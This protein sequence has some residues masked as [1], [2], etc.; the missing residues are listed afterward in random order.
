[1]S[2]DFPLL[3]AA[4]HETGGQPAMT[5][6]TASQSTVPEG[7]G[8]SDTSVI[9]D[10]EAYLRSY[11]SFPD[12]RYFLPLALFAALSTAGTSASTRSRTCRS[13]LQS[14]R[15]ARP[16]S[17]SCSASLPGRRGP[18]SSTAASPRPPCT[19]RLR[20]GK[21]VL[22]D[23]SERLRTPRSPLRPI[24]NG[25][26]RRGQSV[27]RRIGG[28]NVKFSTYCP[29]VFSHLGDVYDSLRDRCIARADA[30]DDGR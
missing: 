5:A 9:A 13:G 4:T 7:D 29:K 26:Y 6:S 14:S 20:S 8:G 15:P 17:S 16:V 19:P 21:T 27:Y 30:E 12:G 22:I 23:E 24:L 18:S 25:G 1:M 28:Q 11:L 10:A 2:D 3:G